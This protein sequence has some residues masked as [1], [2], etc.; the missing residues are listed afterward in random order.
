MRPRPSPVE[1]EMSWSMGT[2]G[3][4]SSASDASE[5]ER[6]LG[7]AKGKES[8]ELLRFSASFWARGE[9]TPA[10]WIISLICELPSLALKRCFTL[11]G[12]WTCCAIAL[13]E[14][15]SSLGIFTPGDLS[16]CLEGNGE[17]HDED[18]GE[19]ELGAAEDERA[20]FVDERASLTSFEV[21]EETGGHKDTASDEIRDDTSG[22][23]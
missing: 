6:S 14:S 15:M 20:F 5:L 21:L 19:G 11:G 22:D 16:P 4:D 13:T 3:L 12:V 18:A 17:L 7:L 8:A 10:C 9:M 23:E 1:G 2:I